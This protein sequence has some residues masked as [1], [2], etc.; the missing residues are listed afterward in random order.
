MIVLVYIFIKEVIGQFFV[1]PEYMKYKELFSFIVQE[2][3]Y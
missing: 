2:N 1:Y 3:L